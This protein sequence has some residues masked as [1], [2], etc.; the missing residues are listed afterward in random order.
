MSR[1]MNENEQQEMMPNM[2]DEAGDIGDEQCPAG[3]KKTDKVGWDYAASKRIEQKLPEKI[4]DFLNG[5]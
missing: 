4:K 1:Q 3:V 2:P 5:L